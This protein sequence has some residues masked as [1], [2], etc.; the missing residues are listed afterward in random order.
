MK[1]WWSRDCQC[2]HFVNNRY[3]LKKV[4]FFNYFFEKT[5]S[6]V[7]LSIGF[8]NIK[9]KLFS[10]KSNS[11]LKLDLLFS[12]L[13]WCF[14]SITIYPWQL[15]FIE[16]DFFNFYFFYFV[17]ILRAASI[18]NFKF[19]SKLNRIWTAPK[20]LDLIGLKTVTFHATK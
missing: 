8:Q 2:W 3:N 18:P 7:M 17:L 20:Y 1:L 14:C 10:F 16:D 9:N 5:G 6:Y 11:T 19:I 4:T 12:C 15:L 13:F